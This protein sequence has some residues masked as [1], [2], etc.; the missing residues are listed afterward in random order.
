MEEMCS[1]NW[2]QTNDWKRV[3]VVDEASSLGQMT[4][5]AWRLNLGA[6]SASLLTYVVF[7]KIFF[8]ITLIPSPRCN[9]TNTDSAESKRL[10]TEEG[11]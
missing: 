2:Q 6:S 11:S 9:G 7:L 8:P 4:P 5:E 10:K 3:A 1:D